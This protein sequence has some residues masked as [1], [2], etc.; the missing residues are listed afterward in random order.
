MPPSDE[1]PKFL[2]NRNRRSSSPIL[3][4]QTK[5]QL[6]LPAPIEKWLYQV[7]QDQAFRNRL[8]RDPGSLLTEARHKLRP[9]EV[10]LLDNIP[11][12]ALVSRIERFLPDDPSRRAFFGLLATMGATLALSPLASGCG[13]D[14]SNPSDKPEPEGNTVQTYFDSRFHLGLENIY[15]GDLHTHSLYSIDAQIWCPKGPSGPVDSCHYA[16]Q[17]DG[18]NLD[19]LSLTDHAEIPPFWFKPEEDPD[20]WQSLLRISREFSN[21]D[22]T[23][24][25]LVIIFPGWEY[26]NTYILRPIGGSFTGYGHKNVILKSLYDVPPTR[27]PVAFP[28]SGSEHVAWD[29]PALWQALE[30]FRPG[31]TGEEGMALTIPHTPSMA[32]PLPNGNHST[33]WNFT[34]GDFV[35][36]VEI[37]S[38]HSSAEG[39]PPMGMDPKGEGPLLDYI[40]AKQDESITIRRLLH[41][42]WILE[43]DHRFILSFLGG[44]DNHM[45]QPGNDVSLQCDPTGSILPF[46]GG[47][48]GIAAPALTRDHLWTGLWRRATL[49]ATAGSTRLKVLMSVE[50]GDNNVFMGEQGGH[51]GK[52]RLKVLAD[53]STEAIEVIVD[54]A[55]Y[56]TISGSQVDESIALEEGRHYIY[57]RA[58][59]HTSEGLKAQTWTSPVYLGNPKGS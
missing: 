29:A 44:T 32:A 37:Y 28:G 9:D 33:D 45:G 22:P 34:D 38:K 56:G 25:K 55:L 2:A 19:F 46:R 3:N 57:V 51:N 10:K 31:S 24:G 35:R 13:D 30:A 4:Q 42:R 43:G 47:I 11:N 5:D 20:L 39:P 58:F 6:I 53:Q 49:A 41:Q 7:S 59:T 48:T 8:R 12:Q 15:W 17:P 21:E 52:A 18:S 1:K 50:V 26:T 36:N 14:K 27:C 16:L 54:G 40:S 23:A